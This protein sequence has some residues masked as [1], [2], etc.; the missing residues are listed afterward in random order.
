MGRRGG[1]SQAAARLAGG[2][3]QAPPGPVQV[4]EHLGDALVERG[5]VL[6]GEVVGHLLNRAATHLLA[7]ALNRLPDTGTLLSSAERLLSNIRGL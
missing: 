1:S 3:G 2:H 6:V 4:G 7:H 5:L